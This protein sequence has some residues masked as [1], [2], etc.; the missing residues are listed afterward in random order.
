M[1]ELESKPIDKEKKLE[2]KG[3]Q[4]TMAFLKV[5]DIG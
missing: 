4:D 2:G 5:S 1:Y 3:T